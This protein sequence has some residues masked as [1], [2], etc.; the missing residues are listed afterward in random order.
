MPDNSVWYKLSYQK[1]KTFLQ[2]L[3]AYF[4][5]FS[6][7]WWVRRVESIA[8]NFTLI[9]LFLLWV[10]K[11]FYKRKII[12][13]W[14]FFIT[15]F[16]FVVL[17]WKQ[18]NFNQYIHIFILGLLIFIIYWF[19]IFIEKI[20]NKKSILVFISLTI[21]II[22]YSTYFNYRWVRTYKNVW[23]KT[24]I[25]EQLY[26]EIWEYIK[27]NNKFNDKIFLASD[28]EFPYWSNKR[29]IWLWD[30]M[31]EDYNLKE[32]FNKEKFINDFNKAVKNYNISYLIVTSQN[33]KQKWFYDYISPNIIEILEKNN[34]IILEKIIK[35]GNSWVK[36][37]KI[38]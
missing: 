19:S 21:F 24:L 7:F 32:N 1:D 37:Y 5:Y 6:Y 29:Y 18:Q 31:R 34:L 11:A 8:L 2:Y 20:H 26:K 4:N 14:L 28:V 27:N 9:W 15:L 33:Y 30:L 16:E 25:N 36:I 17:V 3:D 12:L 13:I 35:I 38:N 22:T 23:R 10:I